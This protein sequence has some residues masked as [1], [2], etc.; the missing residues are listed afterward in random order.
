MALT[1]AQLAFEL[2][3]VQKGNCWIG[4]NA[5]EIL[6]GINWKMATCKAFA[7]GN[8]IWEITNHIAHWR[9]VVTRRLSFVPIKEAEIT[10]MEAPA[11]PTAEDWSKTL[12]RFNNSFEKL[13]QAILA[14][15]EDKL[16]TMLT[17]GTYLST[18]IGLIEHDTYHLGQIILLKRMAEAME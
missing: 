10:G 13:Q 2:E 17:S 1:T 4:N 11:L 7:T 18:I 12:E 16:E 8:S 5:M 6:D 15:P 3:Q 9:E 14:F